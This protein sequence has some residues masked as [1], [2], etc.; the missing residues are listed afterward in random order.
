M[1]ARGAGGEWGRELGRG[2]EA[3]RS[4]PPSAVR[5]AGEDNPNP[6]PDPKQ[7]M[8][9]SCKAGQGCGEM[10]V[11]GELMHVHADEQAIGM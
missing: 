3:G 8:M 6:K 1:C 2:V 4:Q 10:C 11:T 9:V 7:E 5:R